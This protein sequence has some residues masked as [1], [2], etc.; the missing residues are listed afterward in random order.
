M[1]YLFQQLWPY[2]I[3]AFVFGFIIS[4]FTCEHSRDEPE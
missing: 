4:W 1:F 2:V 3:L